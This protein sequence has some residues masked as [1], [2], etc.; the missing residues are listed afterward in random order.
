MRPAVTPVLADPSGVRARRLAQAGRA[1]AFLCLLWLAGLVLAGI[2][3]LPANDLPL[4]RAITGAA[5]EVLGVAPMPVPGRFDPVGGPAT[6]AGGT[7]AG[8]GRAGGPG[9]RARPAEPGGRNGTSNR[10]SAPT[11]L[12]RSPVPSATRRAVGPAFG[13][14]GTGTP[15]ETAVGSAGA[16]SGP[17]Q[18]APAGVRNSGTRATGRGIATAPGTTVKVAARAHTG[19]TAQGNSG[20]APGHVLPTATTGMSAPGQ[21]GSSP[22]HAMTP[23]AGHGNST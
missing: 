11:V 2:G 23:G 1:I 15:S 5:P 12:G 17:S 7:A 21:S 22:G 19:T 14:R 16:P 18:A 10:E 6:D 4:G 9:S 20:A 13:T 8:A 3:I